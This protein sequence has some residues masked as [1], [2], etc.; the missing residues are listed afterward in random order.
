M[1][2]LSAAFQ[3]WFSRSTIPAV[4]LVD[5]GGI[6]N[7]KFTSASRRMFNYPN[8]V[9]KVTPRSAA[10]DPLKNRQTLST[11]EVEFVDDQLVRDLIAANN[12]QGK[13]LT[14]WL[15]ADP[16]N[17]TDFPEGS[18]A[19]YFGAIIETHSFGPGVIRLTTKDP[20][21][22]G[23]SRN[24]S[25][26][27]LPMLT[28]AD[29][30][31]LGYSAQG[32]AT[33]AMRN[34]LVAALVPAAL[35]DSASF[36]I[37]SNPSVGH[38]V[39]DRRRSPT[40]SDYAAVSDRTLHT[41]T[42]L[43]ECLDQVAEILRGYVL[44]QENGLIAYKQ[45]DSAAAAVFRFTANDMQ[46][47]TI[48]GGLDLK[49]I[50]RSVAIQTAW[51][52]ASVGGGPG[53]HVGYVDADNAAQTS[54]GFTGGTKNSADHSVE[55]QWF[56]TIMA[57]SY[58]DILAADASIK[59]WQSNF[60]G[61]KTSGGASGNSP[62]S[63][64]V[65]AAHPG[66]LY[67]RGSSRSSTGV[68][69]PGEIIKYTTV[70]NVNDAY[71]GRSVGGLTRGMFGTV[72]ADHKMT[73]GDV[74]G[75]A[76]V[77]VTAVVRCADEILKRF[78][79]GAGYLTFKTDLSKYAPQLADIVYVETPLYV[80]PGLNGLAVGNTTPFEVVQKDVDVANKTITWR[81]VEVRYSARTPVVNPHLTLGPTT[82]LGD[83]GFIPGHF[84]GGLLSSTAGGLKPNTFVDG[85]LPATVASLT[86]T[87]PY[88]LAQ[89]TFGP[90]T[91][92][93]EAHTFPASRDTYVDLV[94][95]YKGAS[96]WNYTDVANGAGAPAI[97]TGTLRAFKVVTSAG[98]I[99]A[100]TDLRNVAL[101][102]GA[103]NIVDLSI[104][105]SKIG[106]GQ[107]TNPKVGALA[108]DS[109]KLAANSVIPGKIAAGT[110]VNADV[111]GTADIAGTK[112]KEGTGPLT[113][114]SAAGLLDNLTS[115]ATRLLDDITDGSTYKKLLGVISGKASRAS[116][117]G[118]VVGPGEIDMG[119]ELAAALNPNS[120]FNIQSTA[121][122]MADAWEIVTG[123]MAST[124]D[125]V[126]QG[127]TGNLA[128]K[129]FNVASPFVGNYGARS[130][131]VFPVQG[132][133]LYLIEA[134]VQSV[135]GSGNFPVDFVVEWYQGDGTTAASTA[136]TTYLAKAQTAGAYTSIRKSV[137][138]P[139]DARY[140]RLRV[141]QHLY[142]S[143]VIYVDRA[144]LRRTGSAF[145]VWCN[146]S[147]A[148]GGGVNVPFDNAEF[149]VGGDVDL[150]STKGRFTAPV[151][152][153]YHF[154]SSVQLNTTAAN[155]GAVLVLKVNGA[156][157]KN[158]SQLFTPA[159][160]APILAGSTMIE[161]LAGDTVQISV[162]TS[163]S[164]GTVTGAQ[165]TSFFSGRLM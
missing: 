110:I 13:T 44:V 134:A 155:V 68:S 6:A 70:T 154:E 26:L 94:P 100:V 71:P 164:A 20:R 153:V 93:P 96:I 135:T 156:T 9:A 88:Q 109:G 80:R 90:I 24:G 61:N 91:M 11:L 129:F 14:V 56:S 75:I 7:G 32:A 126:S 147:P 65:D 158:L 105:T 144:S 146:T 140:A 123:T 22:I 3:T 121:G 28:D 117:G 111:S 39:I 99:T 104:I 149:D 49:T 69:D 54:W 84:A 120:D 58:V 47:S 10:L 74:S 162:G 108:I 116:I 106:D 41:R 18:F 138:A 15:G 136:T 5:I 55:D 63:A 125:I 157:A 37:A 151:S 64:L 62:A 82:G 114:V 48:E 152:G 159:A 72:A 21:T 103:K 42:S 81:L 128:L 161:L 113:H 66:Y 31:A 142:S 143:T 119:T 79:D 145:H 52:G 23:F 160:S 137:K 34:A 50:I 45:F 2:A 19:P 112:L 4:Y 59:T 73:A 131:A 29:G 115:I 86:G 92:A 107:I 98:A 8:S 77:D 1:L 127:A 132:G 87:I 17:D 95:Q 16:G 60:T 12:L 89:T 27:R 35:Y 36:D 43:Q 78:K 33:V 163:N 130:K 53:F 165:S 141:S 85:A 150:T 148:I 102:D 97:A 101:V 40:A 83:P 25:T 57:N 122:A 67:V 133:A 46:L 38:L 139:A 118:F 30:N 51:E 76:I 124:I